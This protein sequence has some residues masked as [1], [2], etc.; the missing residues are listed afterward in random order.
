[1][2]FRSKE[3]HANWLRE[4]ASHVNQVWSYANGL[5]YKV[6]HRERRFISA[7]EIDGYTLGATNPERALHQ[8][9]RVAA[10]PVTR[11]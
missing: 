4:L 10:F 8:T 6:S 9:D 11:H 1:M 7:V 3:R 5:G 2:L